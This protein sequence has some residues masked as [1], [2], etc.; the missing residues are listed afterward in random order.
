MYNNGELL[1][2]QYYNEA[3]FQQADT[4]NVD[5]RAYYKKGEKGWL[6]CLED[7]V[8]WPLG[9]DFVHGKYAVVVVRMFITEDGDLEN[10]EV[11]IPFNPAFDAIA[12][13]AVRKAPHW[14]AAMS[15]N[16]HIRSFRYVPIAF[17]TE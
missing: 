15:H 3:G 1:S 9:Y 14:E 10:V 17:G 12:L 7:N 8:Y 6:K 13:E 5:K 16:R 4:T 11:H 2:K